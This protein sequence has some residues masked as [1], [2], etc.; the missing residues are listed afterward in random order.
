ME[1]GIQGIGHGGVAS[2]A[3]PGWLARGVKTLVST[4]NPVTL[5]TV[6]A[7][8]KAEDI[9]YVVLDQHMSLIEGSIGAIPRR[10]CVVAEDWEEAAELLRDAGLGKEVAE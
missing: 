2:Q 1:V 9:P 8:L 10:L 4:N 7:L 3:A 5:T 6:G